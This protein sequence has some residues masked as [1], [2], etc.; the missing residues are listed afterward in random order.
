MSILPIATPIASPNQV[1]ASQTDKNPLQQLNPPSAVIS[2]PRNRSHVSKPRVAVSAAAQ[3]QSLFPPSPRPNPFPSRHLIGRHDPATRTRLEK[4]RRAARVPKS[5]GF[6]SNRFDWPASTP[7]PFSINPDFPTNKLTPA[8]S[9][10]PSRHPQE[11]VR[12]RGINQSIR[13]APPA[14]RSCA[15]R[16]PSI[17]QYMGYSSS[18]CLGVPNNPCWSR[19][20]SQTGS[21]LF[22]WW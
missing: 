14:C 3:G 21:Q 10:P 20:K 13:S 4:S 7:S 11:C 5:A 6:L 9:P 15:G 17:V 8:T 1:K 18:F 2:P 22:P 16:R 19:T 12:E